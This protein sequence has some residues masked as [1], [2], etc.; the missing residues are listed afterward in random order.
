[1]PSRIVVYKIILVAWLVLSGT[2]GYLLVAKSVEVLEAA[3]RENGSLLDR[4]IEGPF[5]DGRISIDKEGFERWWSSSV[6]RRR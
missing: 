5:M 2:F 6:D 4:V 1:M 3:K